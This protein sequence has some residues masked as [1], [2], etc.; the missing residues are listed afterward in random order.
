MARR[1][2][3]QQRKEAFL[4]AAS[5]TYDEL[6]AWY[7]AHPEATFGEVEEKARE[8]RRELMGKALEVL[9]NGRDT[10][11]QIEGIQCAKC[12]RRMEYKGE[13]FKR[14]V[15]SFEG[16]VDLERAYY[17]CPECEGETIFPPGR[18]ADAE[19]GPLE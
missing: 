8:K 3:R 6:E 9:V 4:G 7:D 19:G 1:M 2:S 16:D 17:V 14:T 13:R 12:R 18:E 15:Y 5:D 10:G 11:Y